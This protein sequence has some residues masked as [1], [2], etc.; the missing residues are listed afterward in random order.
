MEVDAASLR[1]CLD[2]SELLTFAPMSILGV[3]MVLE[4]MGRTAAATPFPVLVLTDELVVV[5]AAATVLNFIFC[6]CSSSIVVSCWFE[7]SSAM[8]GVDLSSYVLSSYFYPFTISVAVS[9]SFW[10]ISN[11]SLDSMCMVAGPL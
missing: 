6:C 1:R 8:S 10:N 9:A 4:D 2:C 7:G 3:N 11:C 5:V